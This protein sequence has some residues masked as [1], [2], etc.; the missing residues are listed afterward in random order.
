MRSGNTAPGTAANMQLLTLYAKA[1]PGQALSCYS[2]PSSLQY[3]L[4]PALIP[5]QEAPQDRCLALPSPGADRGARRWHR[6]RH[7]ACDY[8]SCRPGYWC[9]RLQGRERTADRRNGS[10]ALCCWRGSR[11]MLSLWS[12]QQSPEQPGT[13]LARE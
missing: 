13:P 1:G 7:K 3:N 6:P 12:A 8:R 4:P 11:E 10:T 2:S 9:K 5:S